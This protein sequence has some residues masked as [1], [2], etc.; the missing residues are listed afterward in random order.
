MAKQYIGR[1][2]FGTGKL[3][4]RVRWETRSAYGNKADALRIAKKKQKIMG[5]GVAKVVMVTGRTKF[6]I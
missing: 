4:D 2:V 5:Y 6:T 1:V 3:M